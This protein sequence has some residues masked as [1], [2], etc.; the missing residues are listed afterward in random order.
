MNRLGWTAVG[1]EYSLESS[2]EAL[3]KG[4]PIFFGEHAQKDLYE[5]YG[6]AYFDVITS[7]HNLEHLDDPRDF[8]SLS[9]DLLKKRGMLLLEVPNIESLQ[10]LISKE[11]WLLLDIENHK[12]HF[13][14]KSLEALLVKHGFY[15]LK[16]STFSMNYGLIGMIE[17]M[18]SRITRIRDKSRQSKIQT[19]GETKLLKSSLVTILFLLVPSLVL[20]LLS[21]FMKRGAV[22]RIHAIKI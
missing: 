15:I 12:F 2:Y 11:D 4:I 7:Y 3:D 9:W 13:S 1:T 16:Q 22:I 19:P 17:A 5:H 8:L 21:V 10:Y 6:N 18:K 20:E 14:R